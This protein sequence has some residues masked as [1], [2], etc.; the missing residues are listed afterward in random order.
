MNFVCWGLLILLATC[1][2]ALFVGAFMRAGGAGDDL[3]AD[4]SECI[5][6]SRP[7][8]DYW[9]AR[10]RCAGLARKAG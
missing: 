4:S 1:G 7:T 10:S 9:C 8:G 2:F 6:R 3:C 5:R